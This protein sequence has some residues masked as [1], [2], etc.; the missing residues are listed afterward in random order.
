MEYPGFVLELMKGKNRKINYQNA[1]KNLSN[2][3]LK[4]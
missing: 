1:L 3:N 2:E 4:E